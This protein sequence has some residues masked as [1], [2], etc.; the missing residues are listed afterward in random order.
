MSGFGRRAAIC[1]RLKKALS[2]MTPD[3]FSRS[4]WSALTPLPQALPHAVGR[5]RADT[6]IIGGGILGVATALTLAEA[7]QSVVLIEAEQVA[8]GASGRNTGFVVPSLKGS[9]GL[10]EAAKLVGRDKAEML[11]RLVGTAGTLVFD[12]IRRLRI[13]CSAEQT[14]CVQPAVNDAGLA[15]IERQRHRYATLDVK[16]EALDATQIRDL[17]GLPGYRGALLL[18]TAGQINPLAY[19]R[20]LAEAAVVAGAQITQG[21]VTSIEKMA[22]SW[23]L[24]T[25]EGADIDSATVIVAT[26]AMVGDLLPPVARAIIP[27][28]SY[29][30][31]TQALGDDVRQRILPGR[32]PLVDLRNHP[33]ALRWSPDNRLVTGGAALIHGPGAVDRMARFLLRR[34]HRLAPGLPELRAE[35][36]WSGMIAGTGDFMP[37]F[38][39]LGDGLFAPIGCNGRG[40]ALTTALGGCIARYLLTRASEALPVPIT[41]PR[42]WKLGP[43]MRFAPTAWLA[44][45]R[46][47]DW[48]NDLAQMRMQG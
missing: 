42:S 22:A 3:T 14:G 44:Q 33:F 20:G 46:L 13:D 1:T 23:R 36:A 34:L 18:P 38:W 19:A 35:H 45:A 26:N 31:A 17:S 9:L 48:Q 12:L 21:H 2:K 24:H 41:A 5:L 15:V 7:G 39:Q 30:V 47:K 29:Q 32:Q 43:L 25:A 28:Q 16:L 27:M 37:R 11:L 8:F 10:D 40:I 6:A 4:L